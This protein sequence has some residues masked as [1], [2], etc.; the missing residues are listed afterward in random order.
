MLVADHMGAPGGGESQQPTG[1]PQVG[2][3][4]GE[5]GD[6]R[7][8]R[9]GELQPVAQGQCVVHRVAMGDDD[10][11]GLAAR[12]RGEGEIGGIV[13]SD[14]RS[15]MV[16]RS[17][18]VRWG[19]C[20]RCG[21]EDVGVGVFDVPDPGGGQ[22]PDLLVRQRGGGEHPGGAYGRQPAQPVLHAP[23]RVERHHGRTRAEDPV[24]QHEQPAVPAAQD[25]HP[26]A[27]ADARLP[28]SGGDPAGRGSQFR[29]RD[30]PGV[31]RDGRAVRV[32][33]LGPVEEPVQGGGVRG[34]YRC[35]A[36][37]R[38]GGYRP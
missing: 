34:R 29:V 36:R 13:A 24:Q 9:L 22:G 6:A 5:V 23:G 32:E 10:R 38:V 37:W 8:V 14:A 3:E 35:A 20:E 33:P 1:V 19:R 30:H 27:G 12:A 2:G 17:G 26:V 4:R 7:R 18:T 28:E 16:A 15:G 11:L 31:V 25:R 21:E